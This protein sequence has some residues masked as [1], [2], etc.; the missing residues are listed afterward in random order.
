MTYKKV[1]YK[2][3]ARALKSLRNPVSMNVKLLESKVEV[4]YFAQ[5]YV[6]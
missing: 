1:D 3:Y 5:N 4:R 2:Y 6:I